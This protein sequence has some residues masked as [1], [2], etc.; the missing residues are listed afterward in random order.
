MKPL[1]SNE[2]IELIEQL[3]QLD[4]PFAQRWCDRIT[5]LQELLSG[6]IGSIQMVADRL[7]PIIKQK[8][9]ELVGEY[10]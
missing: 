2:V 10:E 3:K 8:S 1:L 7:P 5:E 9:I 6:R 4:D